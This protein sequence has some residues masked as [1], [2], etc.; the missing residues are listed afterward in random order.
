MNSL[1]QQC[2]PFNLYQNGTRIL[3]KFVQPSIRALF[4]NYSTEISPTVTESQQFKA[5]V[6]HPKKQNLTVE[7]LVLPEK[8]ADGMVRHNLQNFILNKRK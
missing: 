6:L 1:R 5:A 8:A 7:T 4:V 3:N 2:R